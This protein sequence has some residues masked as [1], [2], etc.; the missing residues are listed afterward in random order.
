MPGA[1]TTKND[2]EV[3]FHIKGRDGASLFDFPHRRHGRGDE[4][5]DVGYV[6]GHDNRVGRLGQVAELYNVLFCQSHVE[7]FDSAFILNGGGDLTDSLARRLSDQLDP[8]CIG[9]GHKCDL[10]RLALGF[11]DLLLLFT[12]VPRGTS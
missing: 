5:G 3:H 7:G 4:T 12:L 2:N 6:A 10:R 1:G 8:F 11:V 9:L